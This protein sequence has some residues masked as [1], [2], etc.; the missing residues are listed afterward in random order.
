MDIRNLDFPA[1]SFD[2]AV[3]KGVPYTQQPSFEY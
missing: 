1:E 2:V 3:D